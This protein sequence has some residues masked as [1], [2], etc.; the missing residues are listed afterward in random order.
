MNYR[1]MDTIDKPALQDFHISGVKHISPENALQE[2]ENSRAVLID[3][4]EEHE[5]SLEYIP[6]PDVLNHPMSVILDRLPKISKDQNI[7]LACPG[8]VRSSKVANLLTM[9]GYHSVA[10]LD[11]GFRVWKARNL[12][13]ETIFAA[14]DGC[15]CDCSSCGEDLN[16]DCC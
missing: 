10:N 9:K 2:L 7:I 11:G 4:R 1:N 16:N 14:D 13:W 3:V 6:L 15:G 8:G 5:V 12:P